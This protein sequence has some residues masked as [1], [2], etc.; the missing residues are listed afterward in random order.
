MHGLRLQT[1]PHSIK[2][3]SALTEHDIAKLLTML[4]ESGLSEE[5]KKELLKTEIFKNRPETLKS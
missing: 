4:K 1:D 3:E 2:Q 5:Y